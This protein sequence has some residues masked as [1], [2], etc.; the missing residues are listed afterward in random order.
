[1]MWVY[2]RA[3]AQI[4]TRYRG[5]LQTVRRGWD[6]R[7]RPRNR[8]TSSAARPNHSLSRLHCWNGDTTAPS[9]TSSYSCASDE[10][11]SSSNNYN[12]TIYTHT[13]I[14]TC[15]LNTLTVHHTHTHKYITSYCTCVYTYTDNYI[16][17]YTSVYNMNT[18]THIHILTVQLSRT[19]ALFLLIIINDDK[20]LN[21]TFIIIEHIIKI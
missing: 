1:M 2:K 21:K 6:R 5:V 18:H 19:H 16:H 9:K 14:H 3:R 20:L 17:V 4:R 8:Q 13:H 7:Y 15:T 11:V 10:T 12:V